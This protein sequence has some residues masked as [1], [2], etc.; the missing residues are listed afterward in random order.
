MVF[1]KGIFIERPNRMAEV[2]LKRPPS[3]PN[4]EKSYQDW[5]CKQEQL[6]KIDNIE[7]KVF[8]IRNEELNKEIDRKIEWINKRKNARKEEI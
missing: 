1:N 2:V 5:L 3:I 7:E 8:F 6:S 4:S